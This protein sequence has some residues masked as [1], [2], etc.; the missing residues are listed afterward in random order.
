MVHNIHLLKNIGPT[1]I[2]LDK[3]L[4]SMKDNKTD[5]QRKKVAVLEAYPR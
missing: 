4:G 1:E 5:I 2:L 3:V